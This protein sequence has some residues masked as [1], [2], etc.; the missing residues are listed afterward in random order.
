MLLNV[1]QNSLKFTKFILGK[2]V[3]TLVVKKSKKNKN[4]IKFKVIDNGI[5]IKKEQ[6]DKIG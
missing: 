2:G 4:F 3:I 1:I 5:G 6:M